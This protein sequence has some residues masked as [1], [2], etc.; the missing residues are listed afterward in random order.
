MKT[1]T[2]ALN[3]EGRRFGLSL[4]VSVTFALFVTLGIPS[5]SFGQTSTFNTP[6]ANTW[7]APSNVTSVIVECWGGGGAGGGVT[8]KNG[9]AGGGGGA[10]AY[11]K[12]TM[13]VSPGTTYNLNVGNG[14]TGSSGSNGGAGGSSWFN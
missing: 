5:L 3:Y 12:T 6:G 8:S 9:V 14:G 11:T 13:A 10:G 4:I 7:M 2:D 1:S